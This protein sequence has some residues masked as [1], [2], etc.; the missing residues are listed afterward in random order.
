MPR[1][2]KQESTIAE[3]LDANPQL[4]VAAELPPPERE[5]IEPAQQPRPSGS[6]NGT[7]Y[8][9]FEEKIAQQRAKSRPTGPRKRDGEPAASFASEELRIIKDGQT[10]QLRAERDLTG[11]EKDRLAAS[12]FQAVDDNEQ[13]WNATQRELAAKGTDINH[14]AMA[15]GKQEGRGR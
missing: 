15:L 1:K 9:T 4:K 7:E 11:V 10:W 6:K 2:K 5:V 8:P 13:V 12:G 3:V 14:V